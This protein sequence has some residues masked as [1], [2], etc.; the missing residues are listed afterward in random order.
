[1]A[2][3]ALTKGDTFKHV[4]DKDPAKRKV[5]ALVDEND[6][7][8]GEIS[9]EEIDWNDATVFHL[10][11]LD[12][13]LMGYI[14]DNASLLT[15]SQ[16]GEAFDIKTR[17]NQTNIDAVRFGLRGFDN[18][19]DAKGVGKRFG[20]TK[21]VIN[22]REYPCADDATLELLGLNLI[23]ELAAKIKEASEV[24]AEDEKKFV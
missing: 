5:L 15:G 6:K 20:E 18:F 8:K 24:A 19:V 3:R 22:G 2:I 23:G 10:S 4:S 9:R 16:G 21:K 17:V 12:V 11:A 14:Y 13:F 1:M 7:S